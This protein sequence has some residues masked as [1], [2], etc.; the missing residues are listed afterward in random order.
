M[1][2]AKRAAIIAGNWKMNK[3]PSETTALINEMKPLVAGADCKVVLC[4]PFVDLDAALKASDGSNIEIGAENCHFEKSGAYTGEVSA[5]MLKEMGVKY[6]I[7]GHSERRQY[8]GE[9]DDTVNKRTK[10]AVAAG[11]TAI[12]CVG[13]V[14]AER[15]A[16]ITSEVVSRQVKLALLG[17]AAEDMSK[18]II[19]Y[20]PVWAIGTG[21][22]PTNNEIEDVVSYIKS[23]FNYKIK[24]LYGG[25]VSEKNIE[26]LNQIN[27]LD[28]FLIGYAATIPS[29]L[30]KIIEVAKM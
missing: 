6:V 17:L 24:V 15:E 14:L 23:L 5:P 27:N 10:A 9:T 20:E 4:V 25:S 2:K 30:R 19:A 16:G 12:V 13:E 7:I 28:G 3:T 26:T 22:T 21:K 11:L 18:I 1:N 8:F 29:S